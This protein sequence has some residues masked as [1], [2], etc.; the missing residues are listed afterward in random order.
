MNPLDRTT[1]LTLPESQPRACLAARCRRWRALLQSARGARGVTLFEVI[2]VVAILAL[3]AGGVG[4]AVYPRWVEAQKKTARTNAHSIRQAAQTW[5]A[6]KSDGSEC[7]TVSRLVEDR[8]LDSAGKTEDP[9]GQ[10]YTI[11]CSA[12]DVT[13]FSIGPDKQSGTEDDIVVGP[14]GGGAAD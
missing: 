11:A 14:R 5:R 4:V 8:E 12:D 6:L 13:V 1:D 7:P 9:W 2:I 3:I 10:P